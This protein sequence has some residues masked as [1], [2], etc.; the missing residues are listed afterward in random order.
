MRLFCE[1]V[2]KDVLPALRSFIAEELLYEYKLN[3]TEIAKRLGISQP[4]VS[5]YLRRIRGSNKRI[6][7]NDDIRQEIKRLC[8][9]LYNNEMENG[10]LA[11]EF[12]NL[13]NFIVDKL[14]MNFDYPKTDTC[15]VCGKKEELIV[16]DKIA[17]PVQ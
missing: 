17:S 14:N 4:A 3:Q 9:R 7:S 6:T 15:E 8:Q 16:K 13:C 5:Q 11:N 10:Q 1:V 2:T 12:C